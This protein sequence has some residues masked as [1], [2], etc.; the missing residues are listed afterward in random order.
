MT[1]IES[2]EAVINKP[3]S[4]IYNFLSDFNNF[5][6]IMPEQVIDWKSTENDCSFTIKGMASLGMEF[7]EKVPSSLIKI[8]QKGK[9][10]FDFTIHCI[11][12]EASPSSSK[13]KLAM[14]ADLN[15]FLKMMAEKPLKKFLDTLVMGYQKING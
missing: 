12:D 6:S 4:E 11:L 5:K 1:K 10:P 15:P 14:D 2:E 8:K 7:E 13:L 3:A 9:A